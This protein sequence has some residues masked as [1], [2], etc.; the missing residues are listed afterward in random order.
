M[1][2]IE[3]SKFNLIMCSTLKLYTDLEGVFRIAALPN[4]PLYS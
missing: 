4:L 2:S 3:V 1:F